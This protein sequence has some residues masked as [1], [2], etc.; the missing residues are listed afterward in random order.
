MMEVRMKGPYPA[1]RQQPALTNARRPSRAFTNAQGAFTLIELLV[2]IAIIA[3][4]AAILF[5][6]F[7]KAREK[8]RQASCISNLKQCGIAI[9]QYTQDYDETLPSRKIGTIAGQPDMNWRAA[10]HP[11]TKSADVYTCMSNPD[12]DAPALDPGY[13]VPMA[14]RTSYSANGIDFNITEGAPYTAF[15]GTPPMQRGFGS[16]NGVAR[17]PVGLASIVRPAECLLVT[18]Q[19][20]IPGTPPGGFSYLALEF[21]NFGDLMFGHMGMPNI[22]FADGHVKSMKPTRT[23]RPYNMWV[24]EENRTMVDALYNKLKDAEDKLAKQ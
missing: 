24:I 4:L 15:G 12:K 10:I 7:A 2:V 18:E 17:V 6:V 1:A 14:Y 19:K 5:P 13:G 3:I 21:A 22:L 8:A 16:V 9:S 11:Y 20:A 23:A